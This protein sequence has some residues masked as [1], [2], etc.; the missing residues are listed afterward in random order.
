MILMVNSLNLVSAALDHDVVRESVPHTLVLFVNQDVTIDIWS[1]VEN[2]GVAPQLQTVLQTPLQQV[3]AVYNKFFL[4]NFTYAEKKPLL[5]V[6]RS[7]KGKDLNI[8][9]LMYRPYTYYRHVE[10]GTGNAHLRDSGKK[11]D[12]EL[13]GYEFQVYLEFCKK[14]NCTLN[15]ELE[16]EEL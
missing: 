12:M 10:P 9:G 5:P 15:I 2:F 14:F 8:A 6:M 13:D 3:T 16:E 11:F 1:G 7:L 4:D